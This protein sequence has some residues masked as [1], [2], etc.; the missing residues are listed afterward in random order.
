MSWVLIAAFLRK[1]WQAILL[2]LAAA[3]VLAWGMRG[4]SQARTAEAERDKARE[5]ISAVTLE[6]D[7]A[8]RERAEALDAA[9]QCSRSV[10][11]LKQAADERE[12][13]AALARQQAAQQARQ[14]QQRATQILATPPAVPG[15]DAASA[16][17]RIDA[18]LQGR[19]R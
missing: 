14:R 15:D 12:K 4:Y 5:Q 17:A 18:W 13:A 11:A 7:K 19:A 16:R 8:R 10:A 6:R 3:A 9:E 1:N 2:A